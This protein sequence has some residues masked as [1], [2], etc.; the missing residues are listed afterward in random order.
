M[1]S[2]H[3][4]SHSHV[5][6][7]HGHE[8]GQFSISRARPPA[9]WSHAIN[10]F[11]E[12]FCGYAIVMHSKFQLHRTFF[13]RNWLNLSMSSTN[14]SIFFGLF[15]PLVSSIY[16]ILLS[17]KAVWSYKCRLSA[18]A[19]QMAYIQHTQLKQSNTQ[20]KRNGNKTKNESRTHTKTR[21][22]KIPIDLSKE[23]NFDEIRW[24]WMDSFSYE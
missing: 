14:R 18:A 3:T 6:H 12:D 8:C 21:A 16:S 10:N 9:A 22:H 20:Y 19:Y 15:S 23:R 2:I 4:E 1:N 11:A 13:L 7:A 5:D 17:L 24:I